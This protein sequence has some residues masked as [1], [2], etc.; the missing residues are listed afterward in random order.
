MCHS[1][2]V[3]INCD[4][5]MASPETGVTRVPLLSVSRLEAPIGLPTGTWFDARSLHA[6]RERSQPG[7]AL[8]AEDD[9]VTISHI[10]TVAQKL[11]GISNT[12]NVRYRATTMIATDVSEK[13]KLVYDAVGLSSESASFVHGFDV[14]PSPSTLMSAYPLY[15]AQRNGV[16]VPPAGLP[17]T[18]SS[19]DLRQRWKSATSALGTFGTY[20]S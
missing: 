3:T 15:G 5:G 16:P 10:V 8:A 14:I 4:S 1:A 19:S 9:V 17:N 6:E 13:R 11:A 18:V 12:E 20:Q 7:I 2:F